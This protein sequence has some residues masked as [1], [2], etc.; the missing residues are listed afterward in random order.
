[1]HCLGS[2]S[3]VDSSFGSGPRRERF[4]CGTRLPLHRRFLCHT[5]HSRRSFLFASNVQV[6][7]GTG[8]VL[9]VF[10]LEALVLELRIDSLFDR[11]VVFR[12]HFGFFWV[13]LVFLGA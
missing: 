11:C 2:G 9:S 1:L 6:R 12:V 4:C 3:F 7:E 5:G 13:A 8:K 10:V